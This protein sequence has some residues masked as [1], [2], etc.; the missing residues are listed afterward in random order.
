M[1]RKHFIKMSALVAVGNS[2]NGKPTA[3][4]FHDI[5]NPHDRKPE[6][7]YDIDVFLKSLVEI[8][9]PSVDRII[10]GDPQTTIRKIGTC[11]LP[12]WTTLKK[13]LSMGINV[14]ITHEPTFYT[15]W[16]LD[17]LKDDYHRAPE[18]AKKQYLSLVNKKKEW[19]LDNKLVIIRSHD[20]IDKLNKI[21]MPYALGAV[22]GFAEKDIKQRT[23]FYNVYQTN[24]RKAIEVA[25][26]FAGKL[27]SLNQPGIA[28]YGDENYMVS[29]VGVGTGFICDPL[30][31][32]SLEPDMC[33]VINDT[34]R[35]W[36]QGAYA[37]DSGKPLIVIDHGTAEESGMKLLSEFLSNKFPSLNIIHIPEGCSYRW[38][39]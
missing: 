26:E 31:F 30:Q 14:L 39:S 8:E 2:I 33:I 25:E 23:T 27:K 24:K 22:L 10:I 4:F 19:I 9:H 7:A 20:V 12:D 36:T 29:T 21:G 5:Q 15:H 37:M 35:T 11:W 1:N 17:E 28:F 32:S 38:V 13:A 3:N 34:V 16:D 6:T 18:H